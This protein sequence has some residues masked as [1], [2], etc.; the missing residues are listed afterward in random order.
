[1]IDGLGGVDGVPTDDG[2]G[3]QCEAFALEV[4]VV[5]VTAPDLA[6]VGEQQVPSQGVE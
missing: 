1:M 2:V 6:E 4:L 5:G 3:Q